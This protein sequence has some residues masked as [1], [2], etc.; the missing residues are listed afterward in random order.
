M[1]KASSRALVGLAAL[2]LT[3][4][5][6]ALQRSDQAEATVLPVAQQQAQGRV[7]NIDRK[8]KTFT[9]SDSNKTFQVTDSTNLYKNDTPITNF[10]AVRPGDQVLVTYSGDPD[11][12]KVEVSTLKATTG[13][14]P[15]G[16]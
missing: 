6:Q 13:G 2:A 5:A 7:K 11:A 8:T 10:D 9:L 4:S 3:G 16:M 12:S 15:P 14:G 1:R